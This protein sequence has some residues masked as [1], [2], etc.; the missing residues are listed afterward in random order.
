[1][2]IRICAGIVLAI[3]VALTAGAPSE[4]IA[5]G[6][7]K[8]TVTTKKAAAKKVVAVKKA[9]KARITVRRRSFL[10]AGTH[11]LPGDRKFTDYALP[12][13]YSPTA[14]IENR[15]GLHRGPLPGPYD[16]PSRQ[17]PWP[18]NWCVGC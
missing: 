8:R 9:P 7:K 5:E 10:D 11:V 12:P 4:A 6:Q 18:W 3:A 1:M 14:V 13:G 16:L 15:A 2:T 17:N